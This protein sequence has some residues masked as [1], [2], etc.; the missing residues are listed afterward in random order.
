MKEIPLTKGYVA[1][2]D[3]E[4]YEYLMQWRWYAQKGGRGGVYAQRDARKH[5]R[6]DPSKREYIFMHNVV[7]ERMG[8][9]WGPKKKIDHQN[10]RTLDNRRCELRVLTNSESNLHRQA[11][12][13]TS[14]FLGVCWDKRCNKWRA[15]YSPIPNRPK[16]HIGRF[17]DELLA[18]QRA[19]EARFLAGQLVP[20]WALELWEQACRE[21]QHKLT[22]LC[23]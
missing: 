10:F 6:K 18:A 3:D 20:V 21:E 5:E 13:G 17:T 23:A 14:K 15:E 2:V 22:S 4:D 16:K 11:L 19:L 7:A 9:K 8:L 1:I 12:G